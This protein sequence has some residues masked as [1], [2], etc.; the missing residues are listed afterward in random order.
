MVGRGGFGGKDSVGVGGW[1]G[2]LWSP[3]ECGWGGWGRDQA[4]ED[5]ATAKSVKKIPAR[6]GTQESG[7][8]SN[9]LL[10]KRLNVCLG[11]FGY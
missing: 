3:Q 10:K 1:G 9:D 8:I 4:S 2:R 7:C 11:A 6:L 5:G